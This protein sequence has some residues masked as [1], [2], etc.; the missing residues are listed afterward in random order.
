T[1]LTTTQSYTFTLPYTPPAIGPAALPTPARTVP[2]STTLTSSG[3]VAPYTYTLEAV[4][5]PLPNG[6]SLSSGGVISGTPTVSGTFTFRIKS[7]DGS[8]AND[9]SD[10]FGLKDYTVTV[11]EPPTIVVNPATIPGA[12]VGVAYSQAFTGSGGTAPYTFSLA[13]GALPAGLAL[14]TTTGELT[15]TPTAAGTF[16]FTVRATDNTNFS[17]TR[18]YSLVIAPPTILIAP[19][20]LT[21][22]TVAAAYSQT[23][24]A[25]GGIAPYSY[26]IVSGNLPIGLSFSSAGVLSG[27]PTTAGS[28]TANIRST[29][30]AGY[31]TTVPYTIVIADAVPVAVNDSATTPSN[32][33]VTVN[34]TA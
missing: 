15:G 28:Y 23:I 17:G 7:K 26:A 10:N 2:Y 29:D 9:G 21:N 14:N 8:T 11:I 5:G 3:G 13:A 6:L 32:Q 27:T 31:N 34:V 16:N 30:D 1:P 12:T 24:T 19:A 18:A 33:A 20:T 4:P 25:S 22:G